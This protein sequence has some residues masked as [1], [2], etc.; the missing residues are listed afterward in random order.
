MAVMSDLKPGDLVY[1]VYRGLVP[2][3]VKPDKVLKVSPKG[4]TVTLEGRGLVDLRQFHGYHILPR[5]PELDA[6]YEQ[7]QADRSQAKPR[8]DKIV[9]GRT[10]AVRRIKANLSHNT[11]GDTI[12]SIYRALIQ[13]GIDDHEERSPELDEFLGS[14]QGGKRDT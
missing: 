5:T 14:A 9:T 3:T 2:K 1:I 10:E 4:R 6:V 8:T 11:D 12:R 13:D 7:Q